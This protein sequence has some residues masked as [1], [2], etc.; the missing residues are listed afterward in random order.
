MVHPNENANRGFEGVTEWTAINNNLKKEREDLAY[1]GQKK[2][3]W[4]PP[5]SWLDQMQLR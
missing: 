1:G 2:M 5:T 3:Q 4:E